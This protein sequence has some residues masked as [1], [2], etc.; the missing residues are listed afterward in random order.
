VGAQDR[1]DRAV[2]LSLAHVCVITSSLP[3]S[4]TDE[5]APHPPRQARDSKVL[6]MAQTTQMLLL[7]SRRLK[8]FVF[9]WKRKDVGLMCNGDV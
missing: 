2:K 5:P 3:L 7:S 8:L 9:S 1:A 6:M 4:C